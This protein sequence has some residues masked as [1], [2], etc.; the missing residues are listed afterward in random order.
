[1]RAVRT[2]QTG[3]LVFPRRRRMENCNVAQLGA[4]RLDKGHYRGRHHPCNQSDGREA[5]LPLKSYSTPCSAFNIRS[6]DFFQ[7]PLGHSGPSHMT[8]WQCDRPRP[9][10][11]EREV[12]AHPRWKTVGSVLDW[13][14]AHLMGRREL[15]RSPPL[16]CSSRSRAILQGQP[17]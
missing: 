11:E 15:G 8:L 16:L 2:I 10:A 3:P 13:N 7:V 14:E 17:W 9:V 12:G 5:L 1:M 4:G 6:N